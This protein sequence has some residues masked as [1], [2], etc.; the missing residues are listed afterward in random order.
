MKISI[1]GGPHDGNVTDVGNDIGEGQMYL[2][3][4]IRYFY[5]KPAD[6]VARLIY[7][8]TSRE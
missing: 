3:D 5:N 2:V 8:N 6:K 4:G 1:L 7:Y